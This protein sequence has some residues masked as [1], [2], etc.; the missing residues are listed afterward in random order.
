MLVAVILSSKATKQTVQ[1]YGRR[2]P[3]PAYRKQGLPNGYLYL[4]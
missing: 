2:T 4:L 3:H 1:Q